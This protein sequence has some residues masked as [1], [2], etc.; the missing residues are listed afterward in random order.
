MT[1]RTFTADVGRST[2]ARRP[3]TLAASLAIAAVLACAGTAVAATT[4][5]ITEFS[6]GLN[7]GSAPSAIAAGPDGNLWFTD[8]GKTGAIGRITPAGAIIEL[9]AG[10]NSES[11]PYGIAAGPEGDLWFTDRGTTKAIGRITPSGAITELT[12]GL[13]EGSRPLEITL[14]PE[15]DLWFTDGGTT[16]A[17]G[18]ITPSGAI[19]EFTA[20]LDE[21]AEPYDITASTE[22]DLWFTDRGSTKAIG[23]ITPS[24]AITEFTAGLDQHT[25]PWDIAAGPE[26]NLWF[27]DLGAPKA[28]G[29]ITPS[30]T[31]TE[32]STGLNTGSVPV[33]I[34]P[35]ADGNMWFTDSGK[36]PAI[37]QITPAG[38]ITEF[39]AGLEASSAP[40]SI[41]PG[42]D[43]DLWF[44][45]QGSGTSPAI[46]QIG[47]GAAP[48]LV[49]PPAVS[50]NDQAGGAQLCGDAAWSSW[51]SL[52]PSTSLFGFDGY[53]WL[54]G[55]SE[56]AVGQSY[57]PAAAD[58]GGQ[59]SCQVT[60]SYP[61][62][63]VTTSAASA[64]VTIL[65]AAR[66]A[67]P[68]TPPPVPVLS[69]V[70]QSADR[71]RAG[72]KLARISASKRKRSTPPV[73]TTVSFTADEPVSVR[74]SFT[75]L[76][77]GRAVANKCVALTSK[78]ARH[79]A[80]RRVLAAGALTLAAR[81]GSNSVVFQGRISAHK[82]LAVGRYTLT[83]TATNTAGV[84]S[85]AH[86]LSFT[87]VK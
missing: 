38:A 11:Q 13:D 28:I 46:G 79:R 3:L 71:W 26:G 42:P 57:T 87:I 60:V 51:A 16:K 41:A 70:H 78:N 19:T 25:A 27:T 59:L 64:P 72:A 37:G 82:R 36:T 17:I 33:G 54:L 1:T 5:A 75:R 86:S 31:I 4:G 12:A 85:T 77:S 81:T 32:F 50:G 43:G 65:A 34:A 7:K 56:V 66:P 23:R 84:R 20:G 55:A 63:D 14:G 83:I 15:G 53:R 67:T 76:L 44:A 10:L 61:L 22:G 58:V 80:C 45:D 47:A 6:A 49:S 40:V 69:R 30:G 73:G 29:R 48:A 9:S 68:L 8:E 18:R 74:F 62:L 52:Q 39:S 24:G 35:G 21:G 2:W